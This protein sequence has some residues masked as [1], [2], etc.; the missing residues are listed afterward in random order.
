MPNKADGTW[1]S[2]R[3]RDE[4]IRQEKLRNLT[5]ANDVRFGLAE[6][7]QKIERFDAA[8]GREQMAELLMNPDEIVGA[9]QVGKLLRYPRGIGD[10]KVRRLLISTQTKPTKRVRELTERQRRVL[11]TAVRNRYKYEKWMEG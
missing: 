4:E 9:A 7:R 8:G 1:Q 11:A 2:Q 5:R 3:Q 10:V 6:I